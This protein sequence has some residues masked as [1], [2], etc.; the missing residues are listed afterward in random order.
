M[1]ISAKLNYIRIAPRKMRLLADLV[2]GKKVDQ[3]MILLDFN[4]KK[5]GMLKTI[6]HWENN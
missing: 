3:A 1:K 4:L 6:Q 5:G 2:R